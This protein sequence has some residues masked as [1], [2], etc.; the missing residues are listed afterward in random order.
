MAETMT[1]PAAVAEIA[2]SWRTQRQPNPREFRRLVRAMTVLGLT[3][4][5]MRVA[6]RHLDVV[7]SDGLLFRKELD[8]LAPWNKAPACQDRVNVSIKITDLN[9]RKIYSGESSSAALK[10]IQNKLGE[11]RRK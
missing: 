11:R 2:N 9:G 1:K 8:R 10:A 6:C 3:P 7:D 5:E 4:E